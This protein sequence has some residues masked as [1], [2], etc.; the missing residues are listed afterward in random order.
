MQYTI[1]VTRDLQEL[2]E[3][4]NEHIKVGW[5]PQGGVCITADDYYYQAMIEE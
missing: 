5:K 4:V 1:L 2:I 3:K